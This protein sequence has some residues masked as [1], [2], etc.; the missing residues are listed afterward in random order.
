MI[1]ELVGA[2]DGPTIGISAAV[3]GNENTGAQAA[4]E[5]FRAL[6]ALELRG[7]VLLLPVANPYAFAGNHRF[8]RLDELDLNRQFPGNPSGTFSQQLAAAITREFLEQIDVHIDLHTGTDRPTVDYVYIWNDEA[9]SRS[10]GSR[11]LY[12][13]TTGREGTVFNGLSTTVTV[14]RRNIPTTVIELGGGIVDQG[15]YVERTVAG[16]IN[17]LRHLGAIEGGV[18]PA[19]AQTV[20]TSLAGVRPRKGGWLEP[21]APPLGEPIAGG[22]PL[23]RIVSPYTFETIEEIV[24][25]FARGVMVMGHLTRNL[26]EAGD[27]GFLVGDLDGATA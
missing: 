7:R 13:P 5:L 27:Y 15:P 12:R 6:N 20:V 11:I 3:H 14:E 1:H 21:L 22:A 9:L 24:S 4:L 18:A 16:V 19:P 10:F 23:A 26:V 8:A 2:A 25:P 17:M